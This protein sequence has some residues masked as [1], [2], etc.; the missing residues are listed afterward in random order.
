VA[1]LQ[2]SG[3]YGL[4]GQRESNFLDVLG[5]GGEQT[6]AGDGEETAEARVAMAVELLGVG[7]GALDGLLRRL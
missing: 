1:V 3:G 6:L 2:G 4:E 5:G 7:E